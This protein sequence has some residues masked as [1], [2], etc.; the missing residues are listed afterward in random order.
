MT[1]MFR[2]I[3]LTGPTGA[4]KST[5][6]AMLA[7]RGIPIIDADNATRTVQAAGSPCLAALADAFGADI[8]LADGSLDRKTLAARAFADSES[9][10][11]LNAI[12]HPFILEEMN[13]RIDAAKASGATAAVL[14]APLLFEAD[15]DRICALSMAVLSSPDRRKAR[16]CARDALDDTAATVRMS[17]G[18]DDAFYRD[19]ADIVLI[20]DGDIDSLNA[21][22]SRLAAEV[23]V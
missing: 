19:R 12:T 6:A 16:I 13:R 14:D 1:T 8:L 23:F 3:G 22:V 7:D 10:A 5:V 18:K 4:G 17:A 21:Q 11:R 9:T 2:L 20:N 15:L